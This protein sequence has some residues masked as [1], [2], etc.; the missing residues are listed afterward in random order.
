MTIGEMIRSE[1]ISQAMSQTE[2]ATKSNMLQS[3]ISR[4]E[5]GGRQM[6]IR[7]LYRIARAL[8]IHPAN[9]FPD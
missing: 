1:R 4:I 7:T 9:L 8:D 5:T 3:D 2:L 6:K